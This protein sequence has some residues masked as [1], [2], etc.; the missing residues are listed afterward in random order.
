MSRSHCRRRVARI[1]VIVSTF[2]LILAAAMWVR[3]R[4][5]YDRLYVKLLDREWPDHF[6]VTHG[7][8]ST[9]GTIEYTRWLP[10]ENRPATWTMWRDGPVSWG[11]EHGS[12]RNMM[13]IEAEQD[14]SDFPYA[15]W[16]RWGFHWS[17]SLG[18]TRE[19]GLPMGDRCIVVSV[20]YYAVT[21][22]FALLPAASVI[23]PARRRLRRLRSPST[24]VHCGYDLRATP[25]RCPECGAAAGP[26]SPAAQ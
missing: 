13:P 2:L 17:D 15:A 16:T 18:A 14:V 20:P 24:C 11:W 7:L 5:T 25:D 12:T 21:L 4:S 22:L 9:R 23:A 10:Q 3:S 19:H 26:A 8:I 1:G 6:I